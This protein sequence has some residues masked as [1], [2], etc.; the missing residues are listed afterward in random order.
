MRSSRFERQWAVVD[1]EGVLV[2][3]D[4]RVP[5][6][7]RRRVAR[8]WATEHGLTLSGRNRDAWVVRAEVRTVR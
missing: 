4:G 6:F 1:A 7:W 8:L 3:C 2:L 5:V